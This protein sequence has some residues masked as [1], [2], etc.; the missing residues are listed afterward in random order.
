ML[1]YVCVTCDRGP[2]AIVGAG[3]LVT[4]PCGA[5][6]MAATALHSQPHVVDECSVGKLLRFYGKN[7]NITLDNR[8]ITAATHT[9]AVSVAPHR[10]NL[11][12]DF[13]KP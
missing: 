3:L 2:P 5:A 10:V 9:A 11:P 12:N 13:G 8:Q 1:G 6:A 7:R 4:G